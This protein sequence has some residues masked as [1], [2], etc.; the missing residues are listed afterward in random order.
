MKENWEQDQEVGYQVTTS[1]G[2]KNCMKKRAKKG[3]NK[4]F[5][6]PF[7]LHASCPLSPLSWSFTLLAM[8]FSTSHAS[9]GQKDI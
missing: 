6:A 4:N 1:K 2:R 3:L 9:T 8:P 7:W 5:V